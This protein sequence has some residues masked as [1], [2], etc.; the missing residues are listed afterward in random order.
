MVSS[1]R[2]WTG[3]KLSWR[4]PGPRSTRCATCC[5]P[6]GPHPRSSTGASRP[7][8]PPDRGGRRPRRHPGLVAGRPRRAAR[9]RPRPG[10]ARHRS[11]RRPVRERD[12]PARPRS[13]RPCSSRSRAP[14]RA[15]GRV[16]PVV[17]PAAELAIISHHGSLERRRP[18]LRQA[19]LLRH[20]PRDQHRRAAARVLC[21]R[22]R[23]HP[24]PGG[25]ED[26]D[27]LAHLPRRRPVLSRPGTP[28]RRDAP[29]RLRCPGPAGGQAVRRGGLP[30][31]GAGGPAGR[32]GAARVRADA[33]RAAARGQEGAGRRAGPARPG[34]APVPAVPGAAVRPAR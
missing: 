8:R 23:R 14:V 30:A 31:R 11:Q 27:W 22:R 34:R 5:G 28:V 25:M 16:T 1:P 13:R 26:R 9:H 32:P 17:V 15:I 20:H 7:P 19:G 2:T 6:P 10:P 29:G 24:G 18:Q 3:W 12:L 21:A 4:R 33:G